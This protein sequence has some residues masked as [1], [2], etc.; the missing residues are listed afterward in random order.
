MSVDKR[1]NGRWRA[2]YRDD[3]GRQRAKHFDRK[4]DAQQFLARMV[5]D[6]QRGAYV[7][8]KAGRE[9]VVVF[10][11]RWAASQPWRSSSRKRMQHII[12]SQIGVEFEGHTL[13]SLNRSHVRAWVGKMSQRFAPSTVESYYRC[14]AAVMIA[15]VD[16]GLI[17]KSPCTKIT[18]PRRES[19]GLALVPLTVDEVRGLAAAV[20]ARYRAAIGAQAG[21]GLRQGELLGLTVDRI[22]FLRGTVRI[23]RQLVGIEGDAPVFGPPKT[24]A[25]NRLVPMASSVRDLLAAHLAEFGEGPERLVFVSATGRP[26][27][28]SLYSQTFRTATASIGVEATSHDLRHHCA[29]LLIRS[30]CSVKAVQSFLGHATAAETLDTY[31]H[32]WPDDE[33]RIRAAIDGAGEFSADSLR[34]GSD[35]PG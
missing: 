18:L 2:R 16:D 13:A 33:D 24:S 23:D 7:D 31:G 11:R 29:S 25:S 1:P 35:S 27:G 12:E 9:P 22:D 14:L 30:N 5:T 15:A 28:R 32:L 26:V 17:V 4:I 19:S 3:V 6:V 10:A 21:L 8:P 20:P 34:T